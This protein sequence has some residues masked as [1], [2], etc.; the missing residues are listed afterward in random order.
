MEDKVFEQLKERIK[1]AHSP[2]FHYPVAAII[3]CTDGT[4]WPGVNI[5]TS[6]P[7]AGICA[8]RNALFSILAR[9]YQK[10]QIKRIHLLSTSEDK[11]MPCFICRQAL[12]DYCNPEV[13]VVSYN[14]DGE[15]EVHTIE[16]LTPYGFG[17]DN[18]K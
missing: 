15:K 14:K 11:I 8:E 4:M 12:K 7:Q 5:E 18:L 9:G 2:Y 17:E 10:D 16:E 13:E 3:E 6:S 1:Y